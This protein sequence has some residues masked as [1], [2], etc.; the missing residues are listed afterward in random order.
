MF[1]PRIALPSKDNQTDTIGHCLSCDTLYDDYTNQYRCVKCRTLVLICPSCDAR[2]KETVSPA[3]ITT[4]TTTTTSY[5][6]KNVKEELVC[7]SCQL[8]LE[9]NKI[10]PKN[11]ASQS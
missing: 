9:T 10:V 1:D 7:T 8:N 11:R 4:T 5:D 2:L 3:A 6:D